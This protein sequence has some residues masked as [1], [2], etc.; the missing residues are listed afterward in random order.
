VV[1][2]QVE[3]VSVVMPRIVRGWLLSEDFVASVF[4]LKSL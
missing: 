2:I 1:K 4:T 3:V